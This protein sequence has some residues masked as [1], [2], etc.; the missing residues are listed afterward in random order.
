MAG[1]VYDLVNVLAEQKECY[2]GLHALAIYKT[3]AVINKDIELLGQI[4][5][6]E[7]DFVG[8]LGSLDAQRESV[9][10]DI[11]LVT[12]LR[13][14]TLTLTQLVEKMGRELEVSERLVELREEL[15]E[16]V[17]Q[18][19]AQNDLNKE[20]IEQSLEFVQFTVN[21]I[22]STQLTEVQ[23]N[24]GRPGDMQEE[25]AVSFFDQKR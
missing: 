6:R 14:E 18:V 11:A 23:V 5:Q 12:G 16:L 20:L 24:Y 15:L 17:K 19:K 21:A 8:R 9:L 25:R 13:Y 1:I 10:K 2:E 4:V 3:D 7:E 22:K